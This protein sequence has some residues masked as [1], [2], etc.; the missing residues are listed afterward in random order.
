MDCASDNEPRGGFV[1]HE[2]LLFIPGHEEN[3]SL[4]RTLSCLLLVNDTCEKLVVILRGSRP[5]L[6]MPS[7]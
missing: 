2:V 3:I 4:D 1:L 5:L 6:F 7:A